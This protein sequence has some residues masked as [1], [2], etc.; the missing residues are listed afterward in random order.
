MVEV[1]VSQHLSH[2]L[3]ARLLASANLGIDLGN[4]EDVDAH[5]VG[6]A[7]RLILNHRTGLVVVV[8]GDDQRGLLSELGDSLEHVLGRV[9]REV[10][11]QFVVDRQVGR[12]HKE[13]VD[14]VRQMQVGDER[15]HQPRLA[16]AGRQREAQRGE[17]AFKVLQRR[18][19]CLQRG[20]NGRNITPIVSQHVRR[21][22]QGLFQPGQR[23]GLWR[24]QG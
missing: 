20:K 14:A 12:Q 16:H 15:T 18:E 3:D 22:I 5:I 13:V 6:K 1:A 9:A 8:A 7:H 23:F 10:G 4:I 17:V 19:L 2:A 21:S 11:N 24:A